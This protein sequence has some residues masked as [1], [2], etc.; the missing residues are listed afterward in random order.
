MNIIAVVVTYNRKELCRECLE[1]IFSS[2]YPLK[3]VILIDNAST[4]GTKE[5]LEENGL[6][7]KVDYH[8]MDSNTGGAGGFYEGLRLGREKDC[9]FFWIMDD[10]TIPNKDTLQELIAAYEAMNEDVSFLASCVYGP[11]GEAMNVPNISEKKD[12]NGYR[13]WY[14]QLEYGAVKLA[15]ATFVSLLISKKAVMKCGLPCKDY[16]IWGDDSEYTMRLI[17]HYGPAYLIGSSKVLH[18]RFNARSLSLKDED[19]EGRISIYAY[20]Y[21]N[22]LINKRLYNGRKAWLRFFLGAFRTAYRSLGTV[23]GTKKFKA[24]HKGV[25]SYFREKKKFEEYIKKE[26]QE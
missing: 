15:D 22:I 9:D 7:S 21:R 6:L 11:N 25:F 10:D 26:L 16:F 5:Y 8:L 13:N 17:K 12:P 1:G 20:F 4:D 24:V 3:E 14:K 19:N 2:S 18:K 23:Y